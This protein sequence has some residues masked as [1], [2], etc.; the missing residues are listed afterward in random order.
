MP[1]FE[2]EALASDG[3]RNTGL[4]DAESEAA[5]RERLRNDGHYPV[6]IALSG[7]RRG[8]LPAG[9]GRGFDSARLKPAAL[10][11]FTR[12]LATLIGAGIPLDSALTGRKPY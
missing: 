5:V 9:L 8:W 6:A 1:V 11:S 3:S 12:Q 2:Y 10:N 7:T 4:M